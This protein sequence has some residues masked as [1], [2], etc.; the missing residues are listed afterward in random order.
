MPLFG[1]NHDE[2]ERKT[3]NREADTGCNPEHEP[4]RN[5]LRRQLEEERRQRLEDV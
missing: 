5:R 3:K 2:I 4:E 1:R